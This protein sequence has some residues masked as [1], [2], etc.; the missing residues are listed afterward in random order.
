MIVTVSPAAYDRPAQAFRVCSPPPRPL[1]RGD[2]IS[3]QLAD[4]TSTGITRCVTNL[5][6]EPSRILFVLGPTR[7]CKAA[8]VLIDPLED[9][10]RWLPLPVSLFLRAGDG[11]R[12]LK[13]GRRFDEPEGRT[14]TLETRRDSPDPPE[15]S[16]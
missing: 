1:C 6:R 16:L 13:S 11:E 7:A 3:L 5:R 9:A 12:R 8:I 10:A 2:V 4:G 15:I 14:V